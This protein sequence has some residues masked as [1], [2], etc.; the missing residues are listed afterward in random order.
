MQSD[1]TTPPGVQHVRPCQANAM[2]A[3]RDKATQL[4]QRLF[5]AFLAA[6]DAGL[7]LQ[8]HPDSV[9]HQTS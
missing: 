4:A 8:L 7:N 2:N 9:R 1:S 6:V 3:S 5:A